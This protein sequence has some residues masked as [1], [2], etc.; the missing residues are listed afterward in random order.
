MS[1]PIEKKQALQGYTPTMQ[2]TACRNC[3][4]GHEVLAER[5]PPYD[6]NSWQCRL[7]GFRVSA[8]AI[9][10]QYVSKKKPHENKHPLVA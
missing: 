8:M 2:R 7:G 3:A 5:M 10:N 6:T 9:C 4:Q 1:T